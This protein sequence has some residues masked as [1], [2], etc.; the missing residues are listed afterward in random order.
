LLTGKRGP[1]IMEMELYDLNIYDEHVRS[2][3]VAQFLKLARRGKGDFFKPHQDTPQN[4]SMVG[5][6]SCLIQHGDGQ[7]VLRQGSQEW[8]LDF[9][10]VFATETESAVCFVAFFGDVEHEVLPFT[11]GYRV[12][13]TYN[14]NLYHTSS[15]PSV[16]SIPMPFHE[17]FKKALVKL[18]CGLVHEYVTAQTSRST[19]C[20][21][22]SKAPT[23]ARD[24]LRGAGSPAFAEVA[25][26]QSV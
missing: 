15:H 14:L 10:D 13:L 4:E 12:T 8:T 20:W 5:S 22:S 1:G 3:S 2:G 9:A 24:G 21:N 25:L 7:L 18:V 11:T 26:S 6:S 23:N 16:P 17:R 19:R